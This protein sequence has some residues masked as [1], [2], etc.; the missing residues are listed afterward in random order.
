MDRKMK[1]NAGTK[2]SELISADKASIDAIAG[3]AK[4]FHRLKNPILR[5]VM[6]SRVTIAEAAKMGGCQVTDI[7]SALTPLGFEYEATE[8]SQAETGQRPEWLT[9]AENNVIRYDVRPII[10]SGTDPLKAILGKFK[11]V[12]PGDILCIIN[13]FVPTPLIRLLEQE[14]AAASYVE[15]ISDNEF[16][17][18]FLKKQNE[19][20]KEN[21]VKNNDQIIMDDA[22]SFDA[23]YRRFS[24]DQIRETDV[25]HLEMPLPMQTILTALADL[26]AGHMLYVRHKRIPVYLLEELAGRDFEVH[27]HTVDESN[28]KMMLFK[29]Q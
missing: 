23:L 14:K 25:R 10:E 29:L 26:P 24:P 9:A 27:I 7:V 18:Y 8:I 17:T 13:S 5:K 6:A 16:H 4:P 19:A 12:A 28:V 15:T 22:G 21:I 11:D 2:I 3:V 20:S 1:I